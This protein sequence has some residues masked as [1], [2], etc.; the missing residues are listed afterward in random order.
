MKSTM[1]Q[2]NV[3]N[4][5]LILGTEGFFLVMS[6]FGKD[7]LLGVIVL[8]ARLFCFILVTK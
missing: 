2:T 8:C 7:N 6:E 1:R 5:L 3:F 4:Y